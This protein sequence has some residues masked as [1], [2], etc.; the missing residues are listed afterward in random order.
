MPYGRYSKSEVRS[1]VRYSLINNPDT[2][3]KNGQTVTR[4]N[5]HQ[6]RLIRKTKLFF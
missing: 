4:E 2:K 6:F 1:M 3:R 5:A